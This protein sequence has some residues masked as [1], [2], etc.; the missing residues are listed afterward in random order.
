MK[1]RRDEEII[2]RISM[3]RTQNNILWM[4]ILEIALEYAPDETKRVLR[5]I[6]SNDTNISDL[7]RDLARW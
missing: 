7:V 2:D 1:E 3:I 4:R 6:H 5:E